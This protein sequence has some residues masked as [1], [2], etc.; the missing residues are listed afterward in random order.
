LIQVIQ[1]FDPLASSAQRTTTAERQNWHGRSV[2][3]AI[4]DPARLL[5]G[6]AEALSYKHRQSSG[7]TIILATKILPAATGSNNRIWLY[8]AHQ[9]AF[10]LSP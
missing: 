3:G 6:E 4:S 7:F 5:N 8:N 9:T 2:A 1:A 10:A